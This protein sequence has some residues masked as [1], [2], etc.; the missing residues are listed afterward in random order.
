MIAVGI[1][2]LNADSWRGFLAWIL[3]AIGLEIMFQTYKEATKAEMRK[4]LESP[5]ESPL[6]NKIKELEDR[7]DTLENDNSRASGELGLDGNVYKI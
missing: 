6:K 7:I 4:E 3:L 5:S 2:L 1:P